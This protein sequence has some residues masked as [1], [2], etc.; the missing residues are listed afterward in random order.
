VLAA[1]ELITLGWNVAL[2]PAGSPAIERL[3]GW[4]TP[5]VTADDRVNV[6]DVPGTFVSPVPVER[7]KRFGL[8]VTVGSPIMQVLSEFDHVACIGKDPVAKATSADP[9]GVPVGIHAQRSPVSSPPL[10]TPGAI[11]PFPV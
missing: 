4:A 10:V 2:T 6:F 11:Q 3:T 1:P 8:L 7:E 5:A 9:P